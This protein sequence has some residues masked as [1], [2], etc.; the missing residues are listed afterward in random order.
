LNK[1][2]RL[3]SDPHLRDTNGYSLIE[4]VTVLSVLSALTAISFVGLDGNGGIRGLIA[5]NNIDEAKALLNTTA[6]DCLQKSRVNGQGK[7]IIDSSIV[8]NERVNPIGFEIDKANG[9]DKCSYFQLV[10]TDPNDSIRF[11]IGFSVSNGDLSKFANPTSTDANS[12]S[13]CQKWA[14]INCKQDQSLKDLVEWK[15]KIAEAKDKC[16]A[17]YTAWLADGTTPT[18]FNRWNSNAESGCP[19]KPPADGST[20]YKSNPT[21]TTNGCNRIVYGL[22]GEF[23]GFTPEDYARALE[24]KYG[25]ACKQW[26]DSKKLA[27]YTNNPSDQPAKLKECGSQEFWFYE[28]IDQGSKEEFDK[29]ICD[30]NLET[31]KA[32]DGARTVQGCGSQTYYFLNGQILETEKDYKEQ[33]CALDKYNKGQEGKDGSYTTTETGASGCGSFWICGGEIIEDQTEADLK[34]KPP[35]GDK[36]HS[37]CSHPRNFK[38]RR[39]KIG[40]GEND[41]WAVC[42]GLT[43]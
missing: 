35:C 5:S 27:N 19:E 9:A 13:A 36:P 38:H 11:P 18:Q 32:T 16:E 12:M 25:Q 40:P 39:C 4:L 1:A 37:A 24:K 6:A 10:P 22:D 30:E 20:S 43:D 34:C 41:Y 15:Q 2:F 28:G 29:K 14:G 23:V 8:S 33:S 42:E 21:C 26:V 7:E 31:E 17:D 3:S